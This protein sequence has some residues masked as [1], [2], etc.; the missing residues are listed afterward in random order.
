MKL[1]SEM[2]Y[3]AKA[4]SY[5]PSRL[6]VRSCLLPKGAALVAREKIPGTRSPAARTVLEAS[7]R[8]RGCAPAVEDGGLPSKTAA[9]QQGVGEPDQSV[10]EHSAH[11]GRAS[12]GRIVTCPLTP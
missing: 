6:A 3:S 10:A 7:E 11:P 12:P 4:R 2:K 8:E 1:R 9:V 5:V